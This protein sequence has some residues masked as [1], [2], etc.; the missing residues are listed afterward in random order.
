MK[1]PENKINNFLL[2]SMFLLKKK[3]ISG[4]KVCLNDAKN[5]GQHDKQEQIHFAFERVRKKF[6]AIA[7]VLG[8]LFEAVNFSCFE[9]ALSFWCVFFWFLKF[10]A[11]NL[12]DGVL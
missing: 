9:R 7:N 6:A 12:N 10:Y 5:C 11:V 2:G 4:S 1:F 8:D 3:R